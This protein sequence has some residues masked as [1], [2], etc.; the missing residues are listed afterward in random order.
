M[1]VRLNKLEWYDGKVEQIGMMAR[2]N[3]L[4][5]YDGK[6]EQIGMIIDSITGMMYRT[7][8]IFHAM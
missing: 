2:L 3:K 4:E 1:V 5:R 8:G 6:V 7:P